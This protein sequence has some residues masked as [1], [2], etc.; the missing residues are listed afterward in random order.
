LLSVPANP[1]ILSTY[2]E[3]NSLVVQKSWRRLTDFLR[4]ITAVSGVYNLLLAA[5]FIIFGRWLLSIYGEQFT[6]GYFALVAMLA[7]FAFNYIFFWNRPLLLALGK[8]EY[9][10]K[11]TMAAGLSKA[12]L[13]F[14]VVP[15][16]GIAAEA[17]LLSFYY[18]FSVGAIVRRGWQEIHLQLKQESIDNEATARTGS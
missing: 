17:A 2:P 8:P 11:A 5:G 14:A 15:R 13:A 6:A 1:L 9:P 4:K 16:Y 3:I 12:A 10:L 18:I 7:G